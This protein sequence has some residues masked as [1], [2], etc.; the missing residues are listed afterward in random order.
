MYIKRRL[1]SW[2]T[3]NLGQTE[4]WN[5]ARSIRSIPKRNTVTLI[6]DPPVY[7]S[8]ARK[9]GSHR[10]LRGNLLHFLFCRFPTCLLLLNN[11]F[12]SDYGIFQSSAVP[13][14]F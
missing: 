6:H 3:S 1:T 8:D 13:G 7:S 10:F 5:F 4:K 14:T 9:I 11:Y 2:T 12:N